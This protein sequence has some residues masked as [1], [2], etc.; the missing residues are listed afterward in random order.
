MTDQQIE[1]Q[2][3]YILE[4]D[5]T[6]VL[7]PGL[8][9]LKCRNLYPRQFEAVFLIRLKFLGLPDSDP[10]LFLRTLTL[11]QIR[12]LPSTSKKLYIFWLLNDLLFL[13]T[14]VNVTTESNG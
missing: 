4:T 7:N 13:K 6:L 5:L 12:I 9:P 3:T 10:L 2:N 14:D 1:A 8:D 11:L